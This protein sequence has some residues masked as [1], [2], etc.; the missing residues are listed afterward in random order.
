MLRTLQRWST[1]LRTRRFDAAAGGRRWQGAQSF[2]WINSEIAAAAAP[3][4]RRASYYAR[5]NPWIANG[6][7]AIVANAIGAGIKPQSQH[8]DRAI[9]EALHAAWARWTD[10]AD[11]DGV[12]DFYG[13]QAIALRAMVETGEAFA[14]FAPTS[15]GGLRVR[16]LD[17]EMIPADYSR[18]LGDGRRILQ[19]I[20]LDADGTR[21]AYHVFRNRPDV[22]T[23]G[24]PL[25]LVRI[26]AE[27]MA[28][29]FSPLAP[30]QLRGISWLAPVLLR[31][32]ELDLYE[33]AQLVRQKVAALFA[34]FVT[35]V[36]GTGAAGFDGTQTSGVLTTGHGAG[37]A[38]GAARRL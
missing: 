34:G 36:N 30:G 17:A 5:N 23:L 12:T 7:T 32:H 18:E 3:V 24:A 37:H 2:G 26:P 19:G 9:R 21:V 15:T 16:L 6:V 14:Q 25:D 28:H 13:L 35:D 11:A 20:E 38:Q 4:R 33:D 29:V 22:P 27:Q 8:P 1:A 10:D 31:L